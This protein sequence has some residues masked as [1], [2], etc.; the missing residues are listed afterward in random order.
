M[1]EHT[2]EYKVLRQARK[3]L[4]L[5]LAPVAEA[6]ALSV[7]HLSRIERGERVPSVKVADRLARFYRAR[8]RTVDA[9]RLLRAS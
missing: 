3:D 6:V 4:G 5:Y 8:L 2:P 1:D 9:N 7:P